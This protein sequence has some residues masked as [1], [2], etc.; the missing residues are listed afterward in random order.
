[1]AWTG[2]NPVTIGNA[3]K[4]SDYDALWDNAAYLKAIDDARYYLGSLTRDLTA[5]SGDVSYTGVGFTPKAVIFF[6]TVDGAAAMFF[7]MSTGASTNKGL[8][9]RQ[10]VS[11]AT[12][13]VTGTLAI[14]NVQ[15]SGN[16]HYAK[17]KSFDADGFTLTWTKVSSPTGTLKVYYLA[18]R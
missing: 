14:Y 5:S 1:M 9:D 12:W 15:G 10:L 17:I 11:A 3:T 8:F 2:S 18:L 7:G 16:E 6:G 4:K 13:G